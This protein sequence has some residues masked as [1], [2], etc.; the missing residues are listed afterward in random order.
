LILKSTDFRPQCTHNVNALVSREW[1]HTTHKKE[2]HFHL[3]CFS[4]VIQTL[5]SD[6]ALMHHLQ[7]I[8]P[9]TKCVMEHGDL[10]RESRRKGDGKEEARSAGVLAHVLSCS[11]TWCLLIWSFGLYQSTDLSPV[12]QQKE[13]LRAGL[14]T[15]AA[16]ELDEPM[17]FRLPR[18]KKMTQWHSSDLTLRSLWTMCFWWQYW[19]AETIWRKKRRQRS[20]RTWRDRQNWLDDR[21]G[22]V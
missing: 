17:T 6:T 18:G 9:E 2:A 4:R 15:V 8:S 10:E 12:L 1:K 14:L 16:L 5:H 7:S 20:F 22:V 11:D 21:Q 3:A 19:T 13:H